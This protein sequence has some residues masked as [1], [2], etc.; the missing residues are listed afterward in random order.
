VLEVVWPACEVFRAEDGGS[1]GPGLTTC[2]VSLLPRPL[3]GE[4]LSNVV[5]P[6]G[7]TVRGN[8]VK[9]T[10]DGRWLV[11]LSRYSK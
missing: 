8:M 1:P 4:I 10:G 11:K 5:Q 2:V 6:A 7:R 9:H 3:M